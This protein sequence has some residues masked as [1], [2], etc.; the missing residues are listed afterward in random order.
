M[1][2]YKQDGAEERP[3]TPQSAN[4]RALVQK[5]CLVAITSSITVDAAS[6][7]TASLT[8]P[9][10]DE[11][12]FVFRLTLVYAGVNYTVFRGKVRA[13]NDCY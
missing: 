12:L 10:W 4:L 3:R 9:F 11:D 8:A 13:G 5:A 1:Q 2:P 6:A 7:S